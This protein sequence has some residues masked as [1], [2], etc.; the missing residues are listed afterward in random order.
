[1]ASGY[2]PYGADW[3]K[4]AHVAGYREVVRGIYADRIG[5]VAIAWNTERHI[6]RELEALCKSHGVS[7]VKA[8][9]KE[10]LGSELGL[11]VAC[12]TVGLLKG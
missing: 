12:A 4:R 5:C 11:D 1:M 2:G 10:K 7:Y 3:L 6:K 9:S 8:C